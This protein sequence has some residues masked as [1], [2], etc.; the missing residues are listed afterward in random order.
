MHTFLQ[1]LLGI[2][3]ATGFIS[4]LTFNTVIFCT[5]SYIFIP[6][7]FL[8]WLQA[9]LFAVKGMEGCANVWVLGARWYA[10]DILKLKVNIT[11]LETLDIKPGKTYAVLSNHKS[12]VDPMLISY[13]FNDHIPF[14]R[15]F[16]KRSL[17]WFPILGLTWWGLDFPIMR[18]HTKEQIAKDPSL[19]LKDLETTRRACRRLKEISISLLN[20]SEGTR[21]TPAK[22]QKQQSPYQ[23][24]LKPRAGGLA[25]ILNL[26]GDNVDAVLDITIVYH[27]PV[28]FVKYLMGE[29]GPIDI[30]IRQK[31]IPDTLRN[32]D[33]HEDEQF[34][35][36]I[37]QWVTAQWE[38][39]EKFIADRLK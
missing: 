38:L 10:R 30:D 12:W 23:H 26:M 39:K 35:A 16:I 34:R 5:L 17:L 4:V 14:L 33:Y 9:R 27:S 15:F 31:A 37:Q 28:T 1:K 20:F 19:R 3:K 29:V 11:G 22:H 25:Y 21:F 18:R 13:A 36:D 24:L 6:F 8:P 2:A 7:K 32:K